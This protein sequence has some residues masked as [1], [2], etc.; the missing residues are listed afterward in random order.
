MC[1]E[2]LAQIDSSAPARISARRLKRLTGLAV[3]G[4]RLDNEPALHFSATGFC[5]C[6]L[7][8]GSGDPSTAT[9]DLDVEHR[10]KLAEAVRLLATETRKF[11]LLL[12]WEHAELERREKHVTTQEMLALL[13]ANAVGNWV[14]Y[15]VSHP[16]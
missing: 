7:L 4:S 2:V 16:G 13:E 11:R 8:A 1:L 9:L 15:H 10:P 14:L 6:D 3:R 5:S 12:A